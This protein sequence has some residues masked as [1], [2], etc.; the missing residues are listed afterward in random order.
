MNDRIHPSASHEDLLGSLYDATLSPRGFQDFIESLCDKFQIRAAVMGTRHAGTQEVKA[1][2]LQG[3]DGKWLES[4]ALNHSG[5]DLLSK[6][7]MESPIGV[8]YATNLDI[9]DQ[10]Q[11]PETGFYRE[12]ARPQGFAHAAGA[13]VMREGAWLTQMFLLRTYEQQ[14]F[15]REELDLLNRLIPHLQ[16]AILLRQRFAELQLS[17][18][19]LASGS[20]ILVIPTVLFD[21]CGRVMHTNRRADALL[22]DRGS[23]WTEGGHVFTSDAVVTRRFNLEL[24]NAIRA[25]RGDGKGQKNVVLLPRAGRMPLMLMIMPLPLGDGASAQ[26]AALSFFFDPE[27]T[28]KMTPALVQC[29]FQLSEAEAELAVALCSGKTLDT[30][31]GERGT[32]IH[33]IRSQL[34]SIF[35]KTGTK[36]QTDLVSLLLASPA[37]F[38]APD[39][40]EK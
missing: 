9:P 40:A 21:E 38:L 10:G 31:A 11:I 2:W 22:R 15:A 27:M 12:W 36:R 6:L 23:I 29:L 4:Y 3:I 33:T 14:P 7:M 26:G 37:Y 17:Q 19:F 28:P 18:R 25:S 20:D 13:M 8:F 16:R 35:S 24:T 32:S 34:K 39:P 30:A 5:E 1:L